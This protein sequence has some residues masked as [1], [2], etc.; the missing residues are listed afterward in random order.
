M[1]NFIET[2]FKVFA[3]EENVLKKI[4]YIST[5]RNKKMLHFDFKAINASRW[6]H[7]YKET[8]WSDGKVNDK[9]KIEKETNQI[10]TAIN[11]Y[12]C[13]VKAKHKYF[14]G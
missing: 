10:S 11:P 5:K 12:V 13:I 1:S 9:V 2:T 6:Y 14:D 7:V 3:S 4:L 8:T